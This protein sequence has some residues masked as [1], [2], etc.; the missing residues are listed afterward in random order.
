MAWP[1]SAVTDLK[2]SELSFREIGIKYGRNTQTVR[3]LARDNG[4][5][6]PPKTSGPK[7]LADIPSL[8]TSHRRLGMKITLNRGIKNHTDMAEMLGVSRKIYALME[9][10]A[11]DFTMTQLLVIS[12]FL[13]E[14]IDNLIGLAHD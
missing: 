12:E 3:R 5:T 1:D 7:P 13:G 14:S 10:G 2:E 8:S 6:R 11:H 9:I 4:I